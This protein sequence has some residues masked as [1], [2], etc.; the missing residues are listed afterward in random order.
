MDPFTALAISG[1]IQ[2]GTSLLGASQAN[3]AAKAGV[4]EQKRQFNIA[5]ARLDALGIPSVEAQKIL[6]TDPQLVGELV[7]EM[8]QD[9]ADL[10]AQSAKIETDSRL[11]AAQMDALAAI[12][13]R[14][15]GLTPEDEIAIRSA[16]EDIA[17][18]LASQNADITRNMQQRGL[19]GAGMELAMKQAG[20]Q[21]AMRQASE[22]AD[23]LAALQ[24]QA[25]MQALQQAGSM[26]G[27]MQGQEFSQKAAQ[28]EAADAMAKFNLANQ[29]GIA[30]RNIAAR[31]AAQAGNLAQKQALEAQRASNRNQEEIQ[32][33]ALLQQKFQNEYQKATGQNVISG[34]MGSAS[35]QAGANQAANTMGMWSGIGQALGGLGSAYANYANSNS[36]NSVVGKNTTPAISSYW[37]KNPYGED[38]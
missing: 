2:A 7:P 21:S 29:M 22:E 3:K 17:G 18:Q 23:R 33:K 25:K 28:A 6:L 30:Q 9:V 5:M 38:L 10:E 14:S 16:R 1:G 24:Y 27:Q 8:E 36:G 37:N 35:A 13:S 20:G 15:K 32:N 31:N 12:Q 4:A 19:G 26:A 11:K 34:Q